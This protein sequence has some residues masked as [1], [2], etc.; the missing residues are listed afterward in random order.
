MKGKTF[1][2]FNASR[3]VLIAVGLIF[4]LSGLIVGGLN[5]TIR[6]RGLQRS[7]SMP[8]LSTAIGFEALG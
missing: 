2:Y 5:A 8:S 6:A 1:S 4:I 3:K 7:G